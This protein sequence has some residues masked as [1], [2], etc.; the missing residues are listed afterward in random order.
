MVKE[1][2]MHW[3]L[4]YET[5]KKK[6]FASGLIIK[7]IRKWNV[8]FAFDRYKWITDALKREEEISRWM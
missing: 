2:F 5:E 8:K 3:K 1:M 4:K 6:E 7:Y